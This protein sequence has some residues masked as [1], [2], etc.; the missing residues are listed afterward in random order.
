MLY[1]KQNGQCAVADRLT[2]WIRGRGAQLCALTCCAG[3]AVAAAAGLYRGH[4]QSSPAQ[5]ASA[6]ATAP[7]SGQQ[8][9]ATTAMSAKDPHKPEI[10]SE[11]ADLLKLATDL[12]RDVDK[13]SKDT[14]SVA[15]VHEAGEIE[16]LAHKVRTEGP[17]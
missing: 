7:A 11:C 10:T 5:V 6:P 16:Q 1:S 13:S 12:K 2:I 14:L 4:A 3:L 17:K 15:V 9:N 8:E